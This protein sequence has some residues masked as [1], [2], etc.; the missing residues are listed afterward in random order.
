MSIPWCFDGVMHSANIVPHIVLVLVF[1]LNFIAEQTTEV[2]FQCLHDS[3]TFCLFT[4]CVS[5]N[6]LS[7]RKETYR[8]LEK[9]SA[10]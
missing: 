4:M 6:S 9:Y 3:G 5:I 8:L 10:N 2:S 1:L 7:L